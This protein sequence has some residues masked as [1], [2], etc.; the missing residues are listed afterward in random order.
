MDSEIKVILI[1]DVRHPE[2]ITNP[3]TD[4][5]YNSLDVEIARNGEQGI[6]LLK[7][8]Q[9]ET[10]LLD[11][12]MGVGITG[13]DVIKFLEENPEYLPPKIYLVTA[14]ITAGP[15]MLEYLKRWFKDGKI[16]A[17]KWITP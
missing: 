6:E 13:M 5:E 4:Q 16:L 17:Y 10:L 7:K 3:E 15:L 8:K 9:Y 11:H 2:W 14:N 1:D 12:D